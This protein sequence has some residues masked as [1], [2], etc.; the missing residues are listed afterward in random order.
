M[1][2]Y[3]LVAALMIMGQSSGSTASARTAYS[4]CIN[5]FMKKS[6]ADKLDSQAFGLAVGNACQAEATA[7]RNA[8]VAKATK[9]GFKKAEAEQMS[10][11]EV[12]DYQINATEMF[13]EYKE[14]NIT[15]S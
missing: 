14:N 15:P 8:V 7:F 6:L 4:H 10:K 5:D 2:S 3:A 12:M 11:D 1:I 9:D 13:N